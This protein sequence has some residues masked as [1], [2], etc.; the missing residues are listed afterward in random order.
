MPNYHPAILESTLLI[1]LLIFIGWITFVG[2]L[3]RFAYRRERDRSARQHG[4][5]G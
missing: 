3:C 1:Y 5:K 2:S 4:W